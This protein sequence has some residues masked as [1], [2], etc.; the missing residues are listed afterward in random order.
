[1]KSFYILFLTLILSS[2]QTKKVAILEKPNLIEVVQSP[3]TVIVD[4][5]IPEQF[6]EATAENAINIPLAEIENQA[7]SLKG[8]KVV[9]FCNKGIQ[10][11]Q[12]YEILKKKGV[13]VYD[14]TTLQNIKAIQNLNH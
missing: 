11:D 4:V 5:R 7:E 6:T 1:M 10:A 12:A 2:C 14:G 13:E 8:K 9:V 3:E